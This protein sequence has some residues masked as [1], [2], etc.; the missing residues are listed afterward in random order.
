VPNAFGSAIVTVTAHDDGGTALGGVDTTIRTFTVTVNPVADTPSISNATTTEDT[1][2]TSGLVVTKNPADGAEVPYVKITNIANGTLYQNNGST[3][4]GNGAFITFVQAAAGLKFTP[5]PSFFGTG[6]F[7]IQASTSN[8]NAGLGGAV[9]PA[10][11]TV[12]PVA[13]T[14]SVTNATTPAQVQTTSGLVITPNATDGAEVTHFRITNIQHGAL[15]Q[16]DG[17]TP[18]NA[19]DFIAVADGAAGLR[20]TP[21]DGF[22]G[23]ASFDVQASTAADVSGLGGG[24]VT[25]TITSLHDDDARVLG[26]PESVR[27]EAA[28]QRRT[29]HER[30]AAGRRRPAP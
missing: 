3:P 2:T 22:S 29:G 20:F 12:T 5:S 25:A 17:G 16:N 15:F 7:D 6:S 24:I 30:H 8:S 11:I 14:P 19:G 27:Q 13:D 9:V 4:I 10:T 1:Q 26:E 21:A 28:D 23:S 18:I